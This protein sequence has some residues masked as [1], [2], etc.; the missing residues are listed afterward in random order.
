MEAS[1]RRVSLIYSWLLSGAVLLML[2]AC[3]SGARPVI[4]DSTP[5]LA[6]LTPITD[7]MIVIADIAN[8]RDGPGAQHAEVGKLT[9]GDVV[10]VTGVVREEDV[11]EWY[12]L[13]S[14]TESDSR[15]T[16]SQRWVSGLFVA[17]FAATPAAAPEESVT[18]T[19]SVTKTASP[20]RSPTIGIIYTATSRAVVP[21]T[22]T[23]PAVATSTQVRSATRTST[24]PLLSATPTATLTLL[25]TAQTLPQE[26]T[27]E[28]P[29]DPATEVPVVPADTPRPIDTAT[30]TEGPTLPSPTPPPDPSPYPSP[31]SFGTPIPIVTPTQMGPYP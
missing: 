19:A 28:P 16:A 25:P 27:P 10:T 3:G 20:S 11:G 17:P 8:V 30:P 12:L 15:D 26:A 24:R 29:S 22:S 4:S 18:R 2:S 13:A 6:E 1:I 14:V 21:P 7:Q 9:K 23:W 31:P 5:D